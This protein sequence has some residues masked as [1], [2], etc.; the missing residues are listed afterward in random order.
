MNM[1]KVGLFYLCLSVIKKTNCLDNKLKSNLRKI[2]HANKDDFVP[3]NQR[4][5]RSEA[6]EAYKAFNFLQKKTE[7]TQA[8]KLR[9][10][11]TPNIIDCKPIPSCKSDAPNMEF[12]LNIDIKNAK[13]CDNISSKEKSEKKNKDDDDEC[14]DSPDPPKKPSPSPKKPP[15]KPS[16]S[17]KKPPK[18]PSPS[19]KKPPKEPA[20]IINSSPPKKPANEEDPRPR[21]RPIG[22]FGIENDLLN[23]IARVISENP[24]GPSVPPEN[25]LK[26]TPGPLVP[27]ENPP[28]ITP[29]VVPSE[30]PQEITPPLVPSENRFFANLPVE[31]IPNFVKPQP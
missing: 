15:K 28:K 31:Q 6:I 21:K 5:T 13:S 7:K 1:L 29:P 26:I 2:K 24:P 18:K 4:R 27:P 30:N 20:G 12:N 3:R 16:P 14:Y 9:M 10:S 11:G 8:N 25:P 17:P 22:P 19:P 23:N